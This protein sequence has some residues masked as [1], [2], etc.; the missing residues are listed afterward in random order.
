LDSAPVTATLFRW[1]VRTVNF[2]AMAA[3]STPLKNYKMILDE[4]A[5]MNDA[6][7]K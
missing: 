7:Q 3:G 6:L 5:L 1:R 4:F 2:S